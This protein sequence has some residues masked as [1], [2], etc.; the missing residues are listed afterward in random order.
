MAEV[1]APLTIFSVPRSIQHGAGPLAGLVFRAKLDYGSGICNAERHCRSSIGLIQNQSARTCVRQAGVA[2]H[3]SIQHQ[4]RIVVIDVVLCG[5]PGI[6]GTRVTSQNSA[7]SKN[8]IPFTRGAEPRRKP[9]FQAWRLLLAE[10][11][12]V[13]RVPEKSSRDPVRTLFIRTFAAMAHV[14]EPER[15]PEKV[16]VA[17]EEPFCIAPWVAPISKLAAVVPAEKW[18]PLP[19]MKTVP[20]PSVFPAPKATQLALVLIFTPLPEPVPGGQ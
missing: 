7:V 19:S 18:K 3:Q 2:L 9:K 13:D 11:S 6:R 5:Q 12:L 8:G 4:F 17:P 15:F 20:P 1:S 14:P 10:V 16:Y